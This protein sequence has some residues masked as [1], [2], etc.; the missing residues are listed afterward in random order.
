[1]YVCVFLFI[2]VSFFSN[3]Y[4]GWWN[5]FRRTRWED[6]LSLPINNNTIYVTPS[7]G[8]PFIAFILNILRGYNFTS[9]AIESDDERIRTYHRFI[10]AFKF[11]KFYKVNSVQQQQNC[12]KTISWHQSWKG[13]YG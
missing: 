4:L 11:G 7:A 10:E 2:F 13:E 8:G 3:S 5:R 12:F 6:S 9:K 1:M